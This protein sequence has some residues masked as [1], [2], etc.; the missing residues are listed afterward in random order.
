MYEVYHSWRPPFFIFGGLG[1][2]Y[3]IVWLIFY[4]A[5][6]QSRLLSQA[7]RDYILSGREE[8]PA[9]ITAA[10]SRSQSPVEYRTRGDTV[11]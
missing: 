6:E 4:R 2:L 11:P 9:Q 1:L 10:T 3:V 5:P 8:V 7:E